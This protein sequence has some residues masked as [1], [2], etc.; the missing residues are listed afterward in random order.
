MSYPYFI[1]SEARTY[2]SFL[3]L[4]QDGPGTSAMP[5]VHINPEGDDHDWD[6]IASDAS[7]AL[8]N[9]IASLN[10][11]TKKAGNEFEIAAASVLHKALPE[12]P[13]LA[14]PDFWIWLAVSHGQNIIKW[15]YGD[16]ARNLKNFGI[17]GAGENLFY[18]IWLRGE[19]AFAEDATDPYHLVRLGDMDFWRSHIFRQGYGDARTFAKAL[20][21]FQFPAS[22]GGKARLSIKQIRALAK[23][24]KRA[25]SNLIYEVMSKPRAIGFIETEWDRIAPNVV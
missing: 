22:N 18:R 11:V 25:R 9:L 21:E 2:L 19:I 5:E 16:D 24:L 13:A 12:H 6:F 23:H 8:L 14:D 17:G 10:D 20:L 15:R 1:K 4:S 3:L 7:T